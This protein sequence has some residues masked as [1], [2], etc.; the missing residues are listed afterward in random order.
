MFSVRFLQSVEV[1]GQ[2]SL[3]MSSTYS[4]L[5]KQELGKE[6][7]LPFSKF[8]SCD[9]PSQAPTGEYDCLMPG[10]G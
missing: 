6:G 8:W 4:D 9:W 10:R 3:Q 5:V 1:G 2:M 7:I